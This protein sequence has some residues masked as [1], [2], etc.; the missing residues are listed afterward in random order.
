MPDEFLNS[1]QKNHF[2]VTLRYADQLLA[3]IEQILH[4][5]PAEPLFPKYVADFEANDVEKISAGILKLRRRMGEAL[6]GVEISP[7]AAEIGALRAIA[8]NLDYI[9]MELDNLNP[10][11]MR[12]YGGLSQQAA[13]RLGDTVT[14]LQMILREII[15]HVRPRAG[16]GS[17][18]TP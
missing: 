6:R 17:Q 11:S 10:Q 12:A 8:T 16:S 15:S 2:L 3:E 4:P 9:D 18:E 1:S 5:D 7:A 13:D 14:N